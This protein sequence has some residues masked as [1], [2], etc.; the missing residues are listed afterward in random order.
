MCPHLLASR[1]TRWYD[2]NNIDVKKLVNEYRSRALPLCVHSDTVSL[3]FMGRRLGLY[4]TCT[5]PALPACSDVFVLDM[6]WHT[7]YHVGSA[8]S[9]GAMTVLPVT[10][11]PAIS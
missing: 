11:A 9:V 8:S 2:L 6:D 10:C 5:S 7:K 4:L 1:W 3:L